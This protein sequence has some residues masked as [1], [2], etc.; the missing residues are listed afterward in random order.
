MS[1]RRI[2]EPLRHSLR[3]FFSGLDS[4]IQGGNQ[5]GAL[6]S[7]SLLPRYTAS[8]LYRRFQESIQPVGLPTFAKDLS[9]SRAS[10]VA[11]VWGTVRTPLL[12]APAQYRFCSN[13][14]P[15]KTGFENFYPRKRSKLPKGRSGQKE[16][17]RSDGSKPDDQ[18]TFGVPTTAD[19]FFSFIGTVAG[20]IAVLSYLAFNRNDAQEI[21]FQDFKTKLLEPGLV[22]RVEVVNKNVAKVYLNGRPL[23]GADPAATVSTDR[24]KYSFHIGSVD[25][26]ER[27]LEEAQE[28]L[29]LDPHAY[30]PV[31]YVNELSWKQELMR[32]AP[33]IL[34]IAGFI[35][36]S[37]RMQ[38]GLGMGGGGSGLG[39]G[40][41]LFSIGKAQVTKL[42]KNSKDKVYFKDVAGCDEAKQ[43]I[44]E[45][46]HFLK[47]PKKYKELGAKIPRGALL[48]GPP[49]TGKTLLAKATAG[50][51]DVPFLSISGSDFMEMFVGIGPSRVRDLFAQA[52]QCAPSIIFIDEI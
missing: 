20:T 36:M 8:R 17:S 1:R 18:K 46:V 31:L 9:G 42:T 40:R 14:T 7:V 37:R 6:I 26:F 44:M 10:K 38:S 33:T 39:G 45:F 27:K 2:V 24:P 48:V 12:G 49:G 32:F 47:K 50:E 52:R 19:Q 35:Y 25:S 16:D 28:A 13:E 23:P 21:S 43:E 15:S 29:G 34:I 11:A 30:V 3:G 5:Q 51:A 4:S 41:G 22:Q